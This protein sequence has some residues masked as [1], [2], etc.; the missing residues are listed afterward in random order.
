MKD[1][2]KDDFFIEGTYASPRYFIPEDSPAHA[3][4]W[5]IFQ[6]IKWA[7]PPKRDNG[8]RSRFDAFSAL[9]W[10]VT[11]DEDWVVHTDLNKSSYNVWKWP[12]PYNA[13]RDT[14]DALKAMGWLKQ[15]GMRRQHR[16]LRYVAPPKTPMRKMK[17]FKISQKHYHWPEIQVKR[18]GTDLD[19]APMD[20]EW[21]SI[22]ANRKLIDKYLR[23]TIDD[24]NEKLSDHEFTLFK[25]GKADDC[26]WAEYRRV[27]TTITSKPG[28]DAA[29]H[30]RLT[31]GR[32]YPNG[33][34]IPGKKEG[35]RQKT[36]IDGKPTTEVDV[37]A[38]SLRLLS[39]DYELGFAL[40]ETEDLYTYG[41][42]SG[43]NREI[44]KKVIQ[45]SLNG[46]S[47]DSERWPKSFSDDEKDAQLIA[48]Q[49]WLTYA[50][51][52][53][54]TYPSLQKADRDTGLDLMMTESD[55]IIRAMN[56]VLDKGIGCLS[57]HDCL[58]VPEESK[59]VAIDAFNEAYKK[60]G[61]KP[62]QLSVGW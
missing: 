47:L 38:S 16:Q 26:V 42:L 50:D 3:E 35:W 19:K 55:L 59:Q 27:Y 17:P 54:E 1:D 15:V 44:T 48:G 61:F 32:I 10:A 45:A 22:P 40:P 33:F 25:Y 58:I 51:A 24:L 43:L 62:P 49:D 14:M 36:L 46:S 13:M 8:I 20:V 23:P 18:A 53:A 52:I 21:M 30:S 9:L 6:K 57:I 5:K 31:H 39:E 60:K 41:K 11:E 37:S 28:K 34:D 2:Q 12:T 7:K 56:Y 4:A 29:K